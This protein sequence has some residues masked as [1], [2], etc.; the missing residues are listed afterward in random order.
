MGWGM[1]SGVGGGGGVGVSWAHF[2]PVF[3]DLCSTGKNSV[4]STAMA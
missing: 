3:Q 2:Q 1:K 4:S